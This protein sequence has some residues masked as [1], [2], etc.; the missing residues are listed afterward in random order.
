MNHDGQLIYEIYDQLLNEN[1][2]QQKINTILNQP[3]YKEEFTRDDLIQIAEID[4]SGKG[5][6]LEWI[7]KTLIYDENARASRPTEYIMFNQDRILDWSKWVDA[8][9]YENLLVKFMT[10]TKR[11]DWIEFNKEKVKNASDIWSWESISAL[12]N[13]INEYEQ[14]Y[15]IGSGKQAARERKTVYREL[16]EGVE[17]LLRIGEFQLGWIKTSEA[18]TEFCRYTNWCITTSDSFESYIED[19]EQTTG[20]RLL[21]ILHN[22]KLHALFNIKTKEIKNTDDTQYT[23]RYLKEI[24]ELI[25]QGAPAEFDRLVKIITS[26]KTRIAAN[27]AKDISTINGFAQAKHQWKN[28]KH[29]FAR[30]FVKSLVN[31]TYDRVQTAWFPYI[32][33]KPFSGGGREFASLMKSFE[34]DPKLIFSSKL[35]NVDVELWDEFSYLFSFLEKFNKGGVS[36]V[37]FVLF[38]PIIGE[39]GDIVTQ[40]TP[41]T[42]K[43]KVTDAI[44]ENDIDDTEKRYIVENLGY[45]WNLR[46]NTAGTNLFSRIL[47]DGLYDDPEFKAILVDNIGK[48]IIE[49]AMKLHKHYKGQ[50]DHKRMRTNMHTFSV[51]PEW[52]RDA[53]MRAHGLDP[54]ESIEDLTGIDADEFYEEASHPFMVNSV[55]DLDDPDLEL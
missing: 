39:T 48:H 45:G 29:L 22:T 40:D 17:E 23:G 47:H 12:Y 10:Y 31:K 24:T 14:V 6:F 44:F 32:T 46:S 26:E 5:K 37:D 42:V 43:Y 50:D 49:F 2:V 16:P 21:V 41:E 52:Q 51:M 4:P 3:H 11:S 18:A 35:Y 19:A 20:N 36:L 30:A 54:D 13:S 27:S 28:R 38:L 9:K 33:R 34:K 1:Q 53:I 55:V 7:V 8:E 15:G 25:R